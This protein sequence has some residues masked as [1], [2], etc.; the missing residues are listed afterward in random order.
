MRVRGAL[1]LVLILLLLFTPT[2]VT[3]FFVGVASEAKQ[4]MCGTAR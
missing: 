2:L 1:V 4:T 3:G